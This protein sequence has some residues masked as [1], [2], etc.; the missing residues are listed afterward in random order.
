ML[1]E[2]NK[3]KDWMSQG[4]ALMAPLIMSSWRVEN[5]GGLGKD[6]G[7]A[8]SMSPAVMEMHDVG[9][10]PKTRSLGRTGRAGLEP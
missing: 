9:K 1:A 4:C 6:R 5:R 10:A 3:T 2:G 7:F 8:V